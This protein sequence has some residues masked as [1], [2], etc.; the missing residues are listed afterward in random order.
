MADSL[1]SFD[2][3][4]ENFS[5]IVLEKSRQVPV[6]VDFWATW[7]G[8]CQTLM[9]ILAKLADEYQGKFIL[10]KVNSDEQQE[11]AA[12]FTIRSIPTVKIFRN[13]EVVDEFMGA[14]SESTIRELL[15]KYI[16]RESDK[17]RQKAIEAM[18]QGD[19]DTAV[20][21]L[22]QVISEEPDNDHTRLEL[23]SL[24]MKKGDLEK[25]EAEFNRI[26]V[27]KQLE[28]RGKRIK[29]S[30]ELNKVLQDAPGVN[31]LEQALAQDPENLD[32]A[33]KLGAR[34]VQEQDY[35]KALEIFLGIVKKN[36]SFMDDIGRKSML[37]VFELL[38]DDDELTKVYRRKLSMYLY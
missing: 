23:V 31:E 38:G 25:A 13:G 16:E 15:G 21:L 20:T 32:A 30:L 12:Q 1:Y 36:R 7:C 5:E 11:L 8:P 4:S 34:K 35:A 37:M 27:D 18:Q 10:A 28:G 6:L 24:Y 19:M 17:I 14:Q 2:V 3:T 29:A 9:P 22:E 26:P 33:Y